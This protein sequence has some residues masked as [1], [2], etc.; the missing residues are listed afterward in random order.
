VPALKDGRRTH[1]GSQLTHQ[2]RQLVKARV[3]DDIDLGL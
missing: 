3:C 2:R 1:V